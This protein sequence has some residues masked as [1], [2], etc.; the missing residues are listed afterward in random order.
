MT[1]NNHDVVP[2]WDLFNRF[3]VELT[4]SVSAG[5]SLTTIFDSTR[6]EAYLNA[7]DRYHDW[8]TAQPQLDLPETHPRV[9]ALEAAPT[10][11]NVENEDVNQLARLLAITRD[12]LVNCQSARM[13]SGLVAF[14]SGRLRATT[15][16]TRKFLIDYV[17]A[18]SPLDLPE[19]SPMEPPVTS[20]K[21]GI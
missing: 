10:I 18:T 16:K 2:L 17:K 4:K 1:V 9:Y 7:I 5:L 6:L 12:E 3:L 11:P 13:P 21:G 20:G 8:I 19:T 15:E 14:D